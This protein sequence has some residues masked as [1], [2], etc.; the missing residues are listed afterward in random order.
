MTRHNDY[1][2]RLRKTFLNSADVLP[3]KVAEYLKKVSRHGYSDT[4]RQVIQEFKPLV[5]NLPKEYVDFLLEVLI[6]ESIRRGKP[7]L[8]NQ[9]TSNSN[10]LDAEEDYLPE[11]LQI[12]DRVLDSVGSSACIDCRNLGVQDYMLF[13]P[14][15]HIRPPFLHLLNRNEDE[16][17][18]LIHTLV[19]VA[20]EQW[21]R[22]EE[23]PDWGKPGSTPLPVKIS[24]PWG[25]KEFWGDSRVYG[26]YRGIGGGPYLILSALMALEFWVEKQI[27]ADRDVEELFKK[28]L[29]GSD[30]VAVLG[31]CVAM[32]LTYPNRCLKAL[33]PIISSPAVWQM[34]V[35]R[36]VS[37]SPNLYN[38]PGDDN[39]IYKYIDERN[40]KPCR[41]L[42]IRKL[43]IYYLFYS[44]DS[45]RTQFEEAVTQFFENLPFR[46]EEERENGSAIADLQQQI[47]EYQVYGKRENYRFREIGEQKCQWWLEPPENIRLR[48]EKVLTSYFEYQRWLELSLW[49]RETIEKGRVDERITLEEAVKTAQEFQQPDDFSSTSE[50]GDRDYQNFFLDNSDTRLQAIAGVAAAIL[51]VDF[52]WTRTHQLI[53]WSRNILMKAASMSYRKY[54]SYD[55]PFDIKVSAGRGLAVLVTEGEADNS[56]RQQIL[57]LLTDSQTQVVEAVFQRLYKAWTIDEV[58]CWNAFSLGISLCL[59][60]KKETDFRLNGSTDPNA[61]WVQRLLAKHLK[62]LERNIIPQLPKISTKR[63][64]V[65]V[66]HD[67]IQKVLHALPLSE[68]TQ[69]PKS[70]ARLFKLVD[71]LMAWTV[72]KNTPIKKYNRYH[73]PDIPYFWN[74]FF[75]K[76]MSDLARYLSFRE[77]QKHLLIPLKKSWSQA[78]SLTTHL[79]RG[80]LRY[81]IGDIK[82]LTIEAQQGWEE[83]CNWVLNSSELV[84]YANYDYLSNDISDAV[85]SIVFVHH[86]QC[87]LNDEW[88]HAGLFSNIIDQ[89]VKVI[90]HNPEAYGYLITMLNKPGW[91]F[92]PEPALEWLSQCVA[93]SRHDL[94]QKNSNGERTA[95][96]LQRIW[97]NYQQQIRSNSTTLKRYSDIVYRLVDAGVPLAGI[98]SQKLENKKRH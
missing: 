1:E 83:I 96:L 77:T 21:R 98:L 89:W 61:D 64:K 85:S 58:L 79:L 23:R 7:S 25:I 80:F 45:L 47:E 88:S 22:C 52:E 97:N 32:T 3:K 16:G 24:F 9:T 90:G 12:L 70:K 65:F 27:E 40:R 28:V 43:A 20:V 50:K 76:F 39:W 8:I 19:N 33:L 13:F 56:V 49:A 87:W 11:Q 55:F 57:R 36:L 14:P 42:E 37:E 69:N 73:S 60:P 86:G 48:S 4:I 82:P 10:K 6:K 34:D 66:L 71:G 91:Q 17:L 30:C 72:L 74:D 26:W 31:I 67:L 92:T 95:R 59:C 78:P 35:H 5:N 93:A 81:Q 44:D 29:L 41:K 2:T 68:L 63:N 94:W 46:Y 38:F 84:K 15:A 53:A 51:I 54:F 18:R 62:N 75:L